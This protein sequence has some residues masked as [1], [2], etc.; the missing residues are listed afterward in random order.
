MAAYMRAKRSAVTRITKDVAIEGHGLNALF[1]TGSVR[2][3]VLREAA[4]KAPRI[5][6][7]PYTVGIGGKTI[8]VNE[9]CVIK[10]QIEGL[11]FTMKAIPIDNIGT[12]NGYEIGAIIG[13]TAMEEW[14]IRID[15]AKGELDLSGLK[16]RE[17][18]E[19]QTV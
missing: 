5:S 13:A 17:F 4:E 19:Y 8:I 18:I 7:K 11:E 3:Y 1:D 6:V 10:G 12:A 15:M 9:E 2:N 16:R 14:E